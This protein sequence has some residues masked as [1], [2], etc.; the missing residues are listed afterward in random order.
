M[1]KP[2]N[3]ASNISIRVA[4]PEDAGLVEDV[5]RRSYPPLMAASYPPEVLNPALE[6]MCRANPGLLQSGRFFV[7][8]QSDGEALGCGGWSPNRPGTDELEAGRAHIRHFATVETAIG[9]GV[10]KALYK[11]CALDVSMLGYRVFEAYSSL[12]AE[13]FYA[14]LGFRAIEQTV[15]RMGPDVAIASIRMERDI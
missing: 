14:A 4:T 15:L 2:G 10:G 11:R 9:K 12:N 6:L 8:F 3:R 13:G 7:A 1:A 5:L